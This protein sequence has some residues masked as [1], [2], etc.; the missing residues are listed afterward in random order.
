M[1]RHIKPPASKTKRIK[2]LITWIAS[3]P[4]PIAVSVIGTMFILVGGINDIVDFIQRWA[5]DSL[6]ILM[7]IAVLIY[8]VLFI[9]FSYALIDRSRHLPMIS[10]RSASLGL[11][12][13]LL[14]A[15]GAWGYSFWQN[16]ILDDKVIV[17]VTKFEGPDLLGYR[18]TESISEQLN[19]IAQSYDDT[20]IITLNESVTDYDGSKKAR[21]LGEHYHADLV[22]WGWY[23]ATSTDAL[24]TINIE[25]MTGTRSLP[26]QLMQSASY[27][28]QVSIQELE[29]YR[30]QGRVSKELSTLFIFIKGV[31][32]FEAKDYNSAYALFTTSLQSDSWPDELISKA[33]VYLY[34][35]FT[36]F[37]LNKS[38]QAIEDATKGIHL[39]SPF[40][41][42]LYAMRGT[43]YFVLNDWQ[44]AIDNYTEAIRIEPSAA[45]LHSDLATAY[46]FRN[47]F[48]NCIDEYNKAISLDPTLKIAYYNRGITKLM[49]GDVTSIDDF[50]RIIEQD[51]NYANAYYGRCTVW[52]GKSEYDQAI[53]DCSKFMA[54]YKQTGVRL[55]SSQWIL[56]MAYNNRGTAYL[57]R[58]AYDYALND[59]TNAIRISPE[60]SLAHINRGHVYAMTHRPADAIEDYT[61]ALQ[62]M[63]S[64]PTSSKLL[65][66]SA[67]G[68]AFEG[69]LYFNRGQLYLELGRKAEAIADLQKALEISNDPN[70]RTSAIDTLKRLGVNP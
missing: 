3:K 9:V 12:V 24:V 53:S 29:H 61:L 6:T 34:Q 21:A 41:S 25:N 59:F 7:V 17:L 13:L 16:R 31:I 15:G 27:A 69:L 39:D 43:I 19:K 44:Q 36:D 42:N 35:S 51:A 45:I 48:S 22:L 23:G 57:A 4:W 68:Q 56:S 47:R 52:I 28:P 18:V 55:T 67:T 63:S 10:M 40:A 38:Q 58:N 5:N 60:L 2:A 30:L 32:R 46:C 14:V 11:L 33:I 26:V 62:F 65:M 37:Y 70:I 1:P 20:I 54:L 49:T 64:N 66:E 50:N 8:L